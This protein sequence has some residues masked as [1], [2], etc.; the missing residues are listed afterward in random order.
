MRLMLTNQNISIDITPLLS[1]MPQKKLE[2]MA[3]AGRTLQDMLRV[4]R[5][6]GQN[7]VGQCLANQGTFYELDHYPK[8]DVYDDESHS[9]F[10]YHAHRPDSGEHGHFHTFLRAAGMP[11]GAKPEVYK[12]TAKRPEGKDALTHFVAIS[13]NKP[14]EPIG[15]FTTNRW[16]TDETFY[17]AETVI[18]M[19]DRFSMDLT[20]PCLATNRALTAIFKLYRPQIERLLI[21]RDKTVK[22]WAASKPGIDVYED[23]DLEITSI[24]DIN[25]KQQIEAVEKALS[26][27][28]NT[29]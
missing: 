15:L 9:Q 12:G 17:P 3:S 16:V 19:L 18:A 26:S 29:A 8:G 5:K 20:Y 13:M 6:S 27:I 24:I 25:I 7:M 23:R 21:E 1:A 28:R 2:E 11:A 14:G 22:Q 4:L 10:Y